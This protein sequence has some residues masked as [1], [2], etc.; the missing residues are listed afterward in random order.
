[1]QQEM[2]AYTTDIYAVMAQLNLVLRQI[3]N[4][5]FQQETNA[6]K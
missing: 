2:M 5:Y 6:I 1:M 3:Y 4:F